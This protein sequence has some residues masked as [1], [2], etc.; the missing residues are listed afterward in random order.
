LVD[1]RPED[2]AALFA[3]LAPLAGKEIDIFNRVEEMVAYH[4]QLPALVD[5]MRL[6]W[7]AVKFSRDIVY[8]GVDEFR[9]RAMF[10]EILNFAGRTPEPA[11]PDDGLFERLALY[12][13]I[14]TK[15]MAANIEHLANRNGRQWTMD[16]FVL[17][18]LHNAREEEEEEDAID[19]NA[20]QPGGELNLY[21]LTVEFLG[22]L[23]RIENVRYL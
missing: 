9:I 23:H 18:P 19:G 11:A 16:D 17:S 1:A 5:C 12:S 14:D 4:G 6:A 22:W 21:H 15:E 10:Y 3:K 13:E 2:V 7:P 20:V 8:W